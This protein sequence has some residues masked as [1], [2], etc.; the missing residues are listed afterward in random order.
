ML[1]GDLLGLEVVWVDGELD[2]QAQRNKVELRV[3]ENWDFCCFQS[4][5]TD[6]LA[7]PVKRLKERNIPVISIDTLL[8]E[9]ERLREV[10]VWTQ[11]AANHRQMAEQSTRYL[12]ERIAGPERKKVRVIHI[13][14][15]SA[16]S[17][18]R[19]RAKGFEN[20]VK[21][22]RVEV[23]GG[24]VRWCDW[25][26]ELARNT[27]DS[28]IQTAE[29]I[30]GAFFH[31]DDMALACYPALRGTPHEKMVLTA[32]DGQKDG[33]TGIRDGRLA[34]SS[35]NP[36][37]QLHMLALVVGQFIVRNGE[38]L[39][40]VPVEISCPSPLVSKEAGNVEAMFYLSDP[41]HCIV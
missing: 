16:H 28:L 38:K 14:G 32:V 41:T 21:D 20:I 17:G 7:E 9:R 8:V 29:P 39:D 40:D 3:G 11:I 24:G 23:I 34:A 25:K 31:N 18:A 37:C 30:D 22:Y 35:V 27:F 12:L 4:V 36:G 33:L 13:G 10:G 6:I 26:P 2:P 1:W 19:D 15:S 5:Q